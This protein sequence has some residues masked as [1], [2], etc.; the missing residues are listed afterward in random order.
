[1]VFNNFLGLVKNFLESNYIQDLEFY[2][3]LRIRHILG[4]IFFKKKEKFDFKESLKST[5]YVILVFFL[6]LQRLCDI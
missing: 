4:L 6:N 3:F 1:M 2:H 5:I